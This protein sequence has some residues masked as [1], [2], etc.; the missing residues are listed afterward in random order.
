MRSHHTRFKFFLQ[1]CVCSISVQ[2][3]LCVFA[4]VP[5]EVCVW[6]CMWRWEVDILN[7]FHIMRFAYVFLVCV[8]GVKWAL[9]CTYTYV[10]IHLSAHA[11]K[12]QTLTMGIF[13]DYLA[14]YL[15]VRA[16]YQSLS[17]LPC[18]YF[19]FF[20]GNTSLRLSTF[21]IIGACHTY[22]NFMCLLNI[23][24]LILILAGQVLYPQ[25]H[26]HEI[27]TSLDD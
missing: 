14:L 19:Q 20:S 13:L 23:W 11:F 27:L 7:C 21:E 25:S 1:V 3:F 24:T 26:L 22:L 5:A 10:H 16:S 2:I 17:V 18:L 12:G 6:T 15:W 9:T 8:Y 4:Y